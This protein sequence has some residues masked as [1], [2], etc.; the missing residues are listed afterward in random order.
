MKLTKNFNSKE[1]NSKDGKPMPLEVLGNVKK[2]AEQLQV[3]RDYFNE[4][5]TIN[6]GYRSPSHNKAIGGV[7]DSQH[8]LG[9]AVDIVVKNHTPE[10]VADVMCRLIHYKDI[11]QGGVGRYNSFTHYD[12]RG[13]KAR[14]GNTSKL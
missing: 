7:K 9:T 2:V 13:T 11:L 6:S 14:W 8:V 3:I 12:I 1:F 10:D 5:I 4:P